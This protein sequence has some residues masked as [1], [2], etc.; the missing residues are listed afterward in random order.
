MPSL[1]PAR[2]STERVGCYISVSPLQ[3]PLIHGGS[4]SSRA[5][6]GPCRPGLV[7]ARDPVDTRHLGAESSF[8]GAATEPRRRPSSGLLRMSSRIS[9]TVSPAESAYTS[10]TC[11]VIQG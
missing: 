2:Q 11:C 7:A 6:Q 5:A 8:R 1:G 3:A 4:Y 10:Q 9:S